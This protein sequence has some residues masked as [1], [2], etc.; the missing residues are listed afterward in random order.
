MGRTSSHVAV[1]AKSSL[2]ILPRG[3]SDHHFYCRGCCCIYNK[4]IVSS[5]TLP[6]APASL[7]TSCSAALPYIYLDRTSPPQVSTIHTRMTSSLDILRPSP[8]P[9]DATSSSR[10]ATK[11]LETRSLKFAEIMGTRNYADPVFQQLVTADFKCQI[12]LPDGSIGMVQSRE[13]FVSHFRK[14]T[15]TRLL[16][17]SNVTIDLDEDAGLAKV[18]LLLRLGD[19]PRPVPQEAVSILWWKLDR[20]SWRCYQQTGMRG[21]LSI[22]GI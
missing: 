10:S 17:V 14:N 8:S 5:L 1:R 16:D 20:G 15:R 13:A 3:L 11:D 6:Y 22:H 9:P 4:V 2:G 21:S 7:Y 19:T 12:E 18:M